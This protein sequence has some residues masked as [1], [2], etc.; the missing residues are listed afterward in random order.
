MYLIVGLGNPGSR[1]KFTRHNAGFMVINKLASQLELELT[2]K[3]FDSLW[4]KGKVS[5]NNVILSMPQTYMNL[6][7]TAVRQLIAFFKADI[8][9]LIVI[10]D[11]LDLS[12]GIVRLKFGGGNAGHKGLASITNDLGSSDFMR[13]R[14]G[15]GKPADKSRVEGYVLEPFK[16]DEE[17]PRLPEI[18]NTAAGAV[19]EIILYGMEKAMAKYHKKYICNLLEKEDE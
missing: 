2:Q 8:K 1:Y 7:G 5:G 13:V 12:F 11:D 19:S 10:H 9:N 15:I 16:S 14:L 17:L 6:S 3:S 4:G 18:I